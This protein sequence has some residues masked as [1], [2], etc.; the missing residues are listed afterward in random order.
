MVHSSNFDRT[1]MKVQCGEC[2]CAVMK[3][4]MEKREIR[5]E[6]PSYFLKH[7]QN[8]L[9]QHLRFRSTWMRSIQDQGWWVS[10]HKEEDNIRSIQIAWKLLR[11][12]S[13]H[14]QDVSPQHLQF[15]YDQGSGFWVSTCREKDEYEIDENTMRI[16]ELFLNA[17]ARCSAP[18]FP[19]WLS[20]RS[21]V[22]SVYVQR[23]WWIEGKWKS[24]EYHRVIL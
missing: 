1:Y 3:M 20:P 23:D 21:S 11:C 24:D 16:T 12:F 22:V 10:M 9:L 2:L 13:R 14:Q 4:N 17:S 15:H 8:V 5:W 19:I 18:T 6:S 7:Q